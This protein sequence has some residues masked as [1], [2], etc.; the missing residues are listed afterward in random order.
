MTSR[1]KIT[2]TVLAWAA[3]LGAALITVAV[4]A[5][6]AFAVLPS[7]TWAGTLV[8]RVLP[9]LFVAGMAIGVLVAVLLG[10]GAGRRAPAI[11]ALCAA[12][13]CAVSHFVVDPRI[14]RLREQIAGP[15]DA[16]AA[17]DPRRVAFG[18]L[19][20]YSVGGLGVAMMAATLSLAFVL[21]AA[22]PVDAG[23]ISPT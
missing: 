12:A 19:H 11:A 3:W 20:G 1:W 8:G 4:V 5:P 15:V 18:L 6:A 16:L 7:R 17:A 10:A 21:R 2:V 22:R 13:A 9:V 14:A 23:R